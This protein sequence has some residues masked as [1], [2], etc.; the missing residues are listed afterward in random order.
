M[1]RKLL[2]VAA[3]ATALAVASAALALQGVSVA[4]LAG[5]LGACTARWLLAPAAL[6]PLPPGPGLA[7]RLGGGVLR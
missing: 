4:E 7:Y 6:L 5:R 3:V 2:F 1:S